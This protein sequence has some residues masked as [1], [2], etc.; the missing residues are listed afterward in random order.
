MDIGCNKGYTS[1]ELWQLWAPQ[2]GV[3]LQDVFN[4][5]VN[6][7]PAMAKNESLRA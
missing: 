7:Y 2:L 6:L 5:Y 3:R 1:M 4:Q